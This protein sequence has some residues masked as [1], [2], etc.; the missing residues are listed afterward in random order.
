M[1]RPATRDDSPRVAALLSAVFD[2]RVTTV[3]GIRYRWK[4]TPPE[5]RLS[6]WLAENGGEVVG[7]AI[8]GIDAFAP[9]RTTAF[10][11]LAVHPDHRARGIGSALWAVLSAHLDEIG[12]RRIVARSRAEQ[13]SKAFVDRC[14][15]RLEGTHTGLAVDPRTMAPPPP[16][17]PG[18]EIAT[19]GSFADDPRRVYVADYES[20]LD[21]PGPGDISGMTYETWLRLTW[22]N[23]ECDRELST[24]AVADGV[25]VGIS[26]LETDRASGR[27][28]NVG[29]GV[30]PAFRGRGL[31]L[32]MK[33]VSLRSAAAAGITRV[34]TQNDDTNAPMVA[35]NARLGYT[36]FSTGHS[37]VLER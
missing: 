35:I 11:G 13:S 29:T 24:V 2:D 34:I 20:S 5:D 10:A 4:S 28:V 31:G 19:L 33:Q 18:I 8:G 27:A 14:G 23:P 1:I 36:P 12:A 15:F 16:S 7:W 9:L 3:A 17:P 30:T 22:D 26:L 21:E 6:S 37:W 25:P 32:L